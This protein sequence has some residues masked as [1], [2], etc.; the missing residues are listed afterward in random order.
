ML[1]RFLDYEFCSISKWRVGFIFSTHSV[2]GWDRIHSATSGAWWS[3]WFCALPPQA[4][5]DLTGWLWL[6]ATECPWT[7]WTSQSTWAARAVW[8]QKE[9][10]YKNRVIMTVAFCRCWPAHERRARGDAVG[11]ESRLFGQLL[12]AVTSLLLVQL[13]VLGWPEPTAPLLVHFGPG[14]TEGFNVKFWGGN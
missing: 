12:A 3:P 11:V 14:T 9:V 4:S 10:T 1:G 13:C 8:K 7:S 5:H 2:S 6:P